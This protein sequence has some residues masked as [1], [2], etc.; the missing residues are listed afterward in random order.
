MDA[1][2]PHVRSTARRVG[3]S[4]RLGDWGT[5][6]TGQCALTLGSTG[7]ASARLSASHMGKLRLGCHTAYPGPGQVMGLGSGLT[8]VAQS[9]A[10][11]A[12]CWGATRGKASLATLPRPAKAAR[13][14]AWGTASRASSIRVLRV[15]SEARPSRC[16]VVGPLSPSRVPTE[17]RPLPA[18]PLQHPFLLY[19]QQRSLEP[20]CTSWPVLNLLVPSPIRWGWERPCVSGLDELPRVRCSQSTPCQHRHHHCNVLCPHAHTR[21]PRSIPVLWH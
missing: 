4:T 6:S 20:A 7:A 19:G 13:E 15:K 10:P 14:T 3:P 1:S 21:T 16:V 18:V 11:T 5:G 9:M 17:P 8:L 12:F 2:W